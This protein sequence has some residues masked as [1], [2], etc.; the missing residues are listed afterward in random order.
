MFLGLTGTRLKGQELVQIGLADFYV[1][2][3]NL[4]K[5][6]EDLFNN[7]N[8]K[9]GIDDYKTIIKKYAEPVDYTYPNENIIEQHFGKSS[10]EEIYK[11]LTE[12]SENTEFTSKL[13]KAL[14]S[15]SP[16]SMH[17]IFEQ[18]TR[19]KQLD[20]A[21]NYKM[22]LRIAQRYIRINYN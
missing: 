4:G 17:I 16:I 9:S 5:L 20:L 3:D 12:A 2:R 8:E 13:V 18:I 21:E 22:D 6:E 15:Q 1:K 7:S 10:L 19:G 11:S 14:D